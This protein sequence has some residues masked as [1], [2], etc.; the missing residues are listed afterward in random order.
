MTQIYRKDRNQDLLFGIQFIAANFI[1]ART[2]VFFYASFGRCTKQKRTIIKPNHKSER[3]EIR[4]KVQRKIEDRYFL[5]EWIYKRKGEYAK[6]L[7]M[8][9]KV[10]INEIP[11]SVFHRI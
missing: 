8:I 3:K 5:K 11:K 10:E 7:N 9:E 2:T 6:Q 1:D 4:K